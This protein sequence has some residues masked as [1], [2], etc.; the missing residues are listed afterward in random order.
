MKS[1]KS[2]LTASNLDF[3]GIFHGR[4]TQV[5]WEKTGVLHGLELKFTI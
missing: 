3:F 4:R 2:M 1:E 5:N